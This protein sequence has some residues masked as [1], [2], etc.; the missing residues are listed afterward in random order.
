MRKTQDL[1]PDYPIDLF[2]GGIYKHAILLG[3]GL[4]LFLLTQGCQN[5]HDGQA[6]R[7]EQMQ[8][9][10]RVV[11]YDE[12]TGLVVADGIQLVK[13]NCMNCH[14]PKLITQSR[15]TKEG[16]EGMIRWMQAKHRL[17]DLGE[18][19]A[20]ILEYLATHYAPEEGVGRRRQLEVEWYD[21][22]L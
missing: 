13:A 18:H 20:T 17:W 5:S 10:I 22:E 2:S 21:L 1:I 7:D 3:I 19:E 4:V 12:T 6:S 9:T 16:W 15:A 14:S 11:Q 8:D